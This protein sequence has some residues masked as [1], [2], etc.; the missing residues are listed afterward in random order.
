MGY[1]LNMIYHEDKAYKIIRTMPKHNEIGRGKEY[2]KLW[3]DYLGAD[4][5]L[6]NTTHYFFCTEIPDAEILEDDIK[7]IEENAES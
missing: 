7:V 2:I 5:T 4:K 6:Q 3:H 1:F